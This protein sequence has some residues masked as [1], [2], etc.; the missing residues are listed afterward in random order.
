MGY[1]LARVSALIGLV[2]VALLGAVAIASPAMSPGHLPIQVGTHVGKESVVVVDG[3]NLWSISEGH[4]VVA[5][6][7]AVDDEEVWPYWRR[8][9]A[10]NSGDL[11]SGDPDLIY[12]DEV[13]VLPA[14][15]R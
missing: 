2:L 3:D 13:V 6:D 4:L 14:T 10:T 12:P 1:E 9:I 5:F 7:R 8:V 15:D 11:R